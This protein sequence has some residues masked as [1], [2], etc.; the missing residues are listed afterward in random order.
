MNRAGIHFDIKKQL[1]KG[2]DPLLF[3]IDI[4]EKKVKDIES[5]KPILIGSLTCPLCV[6]NED[7]CTK[8]VYVKKY[9]QECWEG[10]YG[11]FRV[12]LKGKDKEGMSA[13]A[14]AMVKELKEIQ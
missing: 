8:C 13:T 2:K 7:D 11:D 12:A 6:V 4:W 10:A 9:G 1:K 14:K 3:S 5:G